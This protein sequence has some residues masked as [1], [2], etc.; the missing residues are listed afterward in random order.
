V[1]LYYTEHSHKRMLEKRISEE[2]VEGVLSAPRWTPA[3]TRGIRY[4]GVVDGRRLA[5]VIDE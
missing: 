1:D 2:M 3:T 4:G 5:V